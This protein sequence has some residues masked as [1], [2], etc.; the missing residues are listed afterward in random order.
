[1]NQ[2]FTGIKITDVEFKYS[3]K[4]PLFS[5]FNLEVKHGATVLLGPNGAGKS[6][7]FSLILGV[8]N[9]SRGQV[10]TILNDRFIDSKPQLNLVGFLPQRDIQIPSMTVLECCVYAAWLKGNPRRSCKALALGALERVGLTELLSA[11]SHKISGGQARRLG[12]A[13]ALVGS[14]KFLIL[15]E[16]SS[17]L[18]PENRFVLNE[19]IREISKDTLILASTHMVEEISETYS[20]VLVLNNGR[21]VHDGLTSDFNAEGS[22]L[23]KYVS[24]I[25]ENKSVS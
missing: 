20:R 2:P 11:K 21:L 17:S 10:S 13:M 5:G 3:N 24:L 12:L 23:K 16:P 14:P 18:D 7:L 4:S 9:P 15:D 25:Q 19:L 8:K 1:M 6:T 22:A